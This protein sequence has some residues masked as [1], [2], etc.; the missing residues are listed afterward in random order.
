MIVG[1][2][3]L[4]GIGLSLVDLEGVGP[5][6]SNGHTM[7]SGCKPR[8][9][10]RCPTCRPEL[11][12]IRCLALEKIFIMEK[13]ASPSSNQNTTSAATATSSATVENQTYVSPP[14]SP[15]QNHHQ[16]YHQDITT[17][18]SSMYNSILPP[19][20]RLPDSLSLTPSS[21]FS[22]DDI[23]IDLKLTSNAIAT[24]HRLNLARLNLEYQ[25]LCDSFDLCFARLQAL[26]RE[27]E[28]LRRENSDLRVANTELI[29][30]LNLSSQAAMNNRNLQR[31]VLPDLNV[32]GCE[33]RNKNAQRNS[34]P[35]SVSVR[36]R[37]Y[38][39]VNQK[40]QGSSNQKRVVNPSVS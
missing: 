37:N 3:G 10:N 22:S 23:H 32:K 4:K 8:V 40:Q 39:K 13:P 11:G 19:K 24:E 30:L 6:C 25:Q 26:I 2:F 35:K 16:Y 33:R 18:F 34:L 1:G 29:K 31:E 9:H 14:P 27:L 15:I 17:D 36:S 12:N 7:C 28:T 20:Y 5:K 21:C 38:H